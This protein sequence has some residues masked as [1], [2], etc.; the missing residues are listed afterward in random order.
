[1][2]ERERRRRRYRKASLY[3]GQLEEMVIT[4]KRGKKGRGDEKV[5]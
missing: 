2:S 1:M 3:R 4:G 5:R